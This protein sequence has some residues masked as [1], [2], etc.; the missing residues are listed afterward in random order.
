LTT[1]RKTALVT[2][3][4]G[5]IGSHVIDRLLERGWT[6][7][8][9]DNLRL[10]RRANLQAALQHHDLTFVEAD[11][12]DY[13]DN[14]RRLR[15][16]HARQPIHVVWHLAANSDIRAGAAD[17]QVD[18]EHTFLTTFNVLKL[19]RALGVRQLLFSS[20][21]AV[22]GPRP[23]LLTEDTGPCFPISN[24]GAMK[25]AS[26]GAISAALETHLERAWIVRFP[27]VVGPR[28]TH[29]V[30][31]DLLE[32]LRADPAA[33][34][35]LGDGRQEKPY[36]HVG[37]LVDAM[38]FVVD[39]AGDRLSCFNVGTD[40]STT[41]V[42]RIAQTVVRTVA[43]GATIRYTGGAQ[44]WP[45]DVPRFQYSIE[46]L[47]RLGW[48]P[49]LAS[50]QAVERAVVEVAAERGAGPSRPAPSQSFP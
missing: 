33:L 39:H 27:N 49:Q 32:K 24:Y 7:M 29:G 35:V 13:E 21:S 50:D 20:S 22:Y 15:E 2:G 30:I 18:L 5:F 36:L 11:V 17:P 4:A 40:G 8:G 1:Q 6:V 45:G 46:R 42:A 37:E 43:P 44:G 9:I 28:S 47:R 26:E 10:G 38:L 14:L 48:T 3:A 25:L 19:M 23:G 12:N 16:W 31:V 34:E 41:T